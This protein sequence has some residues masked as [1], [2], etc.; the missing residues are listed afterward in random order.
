MLGKNLIKDAGVKAM[1]DNAR[2]REFYD[3]VYY[4]HALVILGYS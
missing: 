4:S 1:S 2:M 3:R